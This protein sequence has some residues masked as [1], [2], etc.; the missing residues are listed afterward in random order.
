MIFVIMAVRLH[1]VQHEE[2]IRKSGIRSLAPGWLAE[3]VQFNNGS[4]SGDTTGES[5]P[6]EAIS[7]GSMPRLR[8]QGSDLFLSSK[9]VELSH[10]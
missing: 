9:A 7:T 3:S 1:L 5:Y 8:N 2:L 4:S 6:L 10:G